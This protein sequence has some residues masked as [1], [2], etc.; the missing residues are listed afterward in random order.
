MSGNPHHFALP[1]PPSDHENDSSKNLIFMK[2]FL[3][4]YPSSFSILYVI[5]RRYK[6]ERVNAGKYAIACDVIFFFWRMWTIEEIMHER[7]VHYLRRILRKEKEG[8]RWILIDWF[9]LLGY[10]RNQTAPMSPRS[11]SAYTNAYGS[12]ASYAVPSPGFLNG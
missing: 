8:L 9:L 2:I 4:S 6:R 1:T 7:L 11:Y 5:I 10:S 12:S 3:W